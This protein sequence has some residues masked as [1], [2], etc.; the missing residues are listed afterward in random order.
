M[1]TVNSLI[2][3]LSSLLKITKIYL[4]Q[5]EKYYH[6]FLISRHILSYD[7][8]LSSIIS[9]H[10]RTAYLIFI[11]SYIISYHLKSYIIMWYWYH[12]IL[13]HIKSDLLISW[14]RN[15]KNKIVS[16]LN[17]QISNDISLLSCLK[18]PRSE[19]GRGVFNSSFSAIEE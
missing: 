2:I 8:I 16:K 13:Y 14:N 6:H 19:N 1:L 9:Y 18:L 7:I 11:W 3:R 10:T 12:I 15:H 5:L 4:S 17:R